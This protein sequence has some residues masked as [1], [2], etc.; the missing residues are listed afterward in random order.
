MHTVNSWK[1]SSLSYI[2]A[3]FQRHCGQSRWSRA[4]WIK[5][6]LLK[7]LKSLFLMCRISGTS[8]GPYFSMLSPPRKLA[9]STSV[10]VILL[11]S[12]HLTPE[13]TTFFNSFLVAGLIL[14]W[15]QVSRSFILWPECESRSVTNTVS[16]EKDFLNLYFCQTANLSGR[17]GYGSFKKSFRAGSRH[18][19]EWACE[20]LCPLK[21]CWSTAFGTRVSRTSGHFRSRDW[22]TSC[23][24]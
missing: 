2:S 24:V 20:I 13:A 21:H 5:S 18:T 7:L 16:V 15:V 19:V 10:R 11:I 4:D 22:S 17:P 1:S 3:N 6:F 8:S 14:E 23:F 12:F 9:F